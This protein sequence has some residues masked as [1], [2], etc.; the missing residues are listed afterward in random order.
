MLHNTSFPLFGGV[1][2][3]DDFI[4]RPIEW[5]DL[6]FPPHNDSE[7]IFSFPCRSWNFMSG[8]IGSFERNMVIS[9]FF[10]SF[11]SFPRTVGA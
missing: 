5:S 11:L 7:A 3:G 6:P 9:F 2:P 10:F 4:S 1:N 8:P